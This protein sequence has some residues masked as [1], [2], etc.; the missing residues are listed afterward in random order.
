MRSDDASSPD[1][2]TKG[3]T[4]LPKF[5][6]LYPMLFFGAF[7][8]FCGAQK[9]GSPLSSD[10]GTIEGIKS[11]DE[12]DMVE[13][14][15]QRT[16]TRAEVAASTP[17]PRRSDRSRQDPPRPDDINSAAYRA[18]VEISR[19]ERRA[20]LRYI[21]DCRA[22]AG[23]LT[24]AV[25][26]D[27]IG[28]AIVDGVLGL[29]G[30]DGPQ[31]FKALW[32]QA[33]PH[34]N[35]A[36]I[37]ARFAKFR[38]TASMSIVDFITKMNA[39]FKQ[40][41]AAG[42][43][44]T[45][46]DKLDEM[47]TRIAAKHVDF[48]HQCRL[49]CGDNWLVVCQRLADTSELQRLRE[50]TFDAVDSA[51][52]L[53]TRKSESKAA[54]KCTTCK[55]TGH[56]AKE[57][58]S[59][60][61]LTQEERDVRF[62]AMKEK[63]IKA[64]T[65]RTIDK[66]VKAARRAEA[67]EEA[68]EDDVAAVNE[69]HA[70]KAD[71]VVT[72][73]DE[74]TDDDAV[75]E[76]RAS[77]ATASSCGKACVGHS[78]EDD[79]CTPTGTDNDSDVDD[80]SPV[81]SEDDEVSLDDADEVS[82]EGA[83]A[84]VAHVHDA[85][86]AVDD[87]TTRR[88]PRRRDNE[89]NAHYQ[90]KWST[91][92]RF[93]VYAGFLALVVWGF[94]NLPG[95]SAA[96]AN[97]ATHIG[98][99]A[100]VA[101]LNDLPAPMQLKPAPPELPKWATDGYE[102][103][104]ATVRAKRKKGLRAQALRA[105]RTARLIYDGGATH[106]FL[107][108]KQFFTSYQAFKD[109]SHT[110]KVADDS[111]LP[112]AGHGPAIVPMRD[113]LGRTVQ[114]PLKNAIHVPA[115]AESLVS[116][117]QFYECG[118]ASHFD[119]RVGAQL[120]IPSKGGPDIV[121]P[122]MH[123]GRTFFFSHVQQRKHTA[124]M[125]VVK[126]RKRTVPNVAKQKKRAEPKAALTADAGTG[127]ERASDQTNSTQ[128]ESEGTNEYSS[129]TDTS[130]H[131][132]PSP[133]LN[134]TTKPYT[135]SARRTTVA[136]PCDAFYS[137]HAFDVADVQNNADK[138]RGHVH[139]DGT[140]A[141]AKATP[142][143]VFIAAVAAAAAYPP[144]AG[145]VLNT[146][147]PPAAPP[148]APAIEPDALPATPDFEER[149]PTSLGNP[150][151]HSESA[152][153]SAETRNDTRVDAICKATAN[154][155]AQ[156]AEAPSKAQAEA[157]RIHACFGHAR[158]KDVYATI[159]KGM[160]LRKHGA[161]PRSLTC[162]CRGCALAKLTRAPRSK[163]KR[164]DATRP[165]E[166]IDTDYFEV[167]DKSF[168]GCTTAITFTD[169][170]SKYRWVF[171][172]KST[173]LGP[174]VFEKFIADRRAEGL[175]QGTVVLQG[176]NAMLTQAFRAACRRAG[177][178]PQACAPYAHWQNGIA[179]RGFRTLAESTKAMLL[180]A[181]LPK[182]FWALAFQHAAHVMNGVGRESV[183]HVT[184]HEKLHGT[185]FNA[186]HLLPFAELVVVRKE[187]RGKL[188]A[189]GRPGLYV[190][191]SRYHPSGTI[192]VFMPDTKRVVLTNAYSVVQYEDD[193]TPTMHRWRI[194]ANGADDKW[195]VIATSR[196]TGATP[197]TPQP[198]SLPLF[199][200]TDE[201]PNI[202]GQG[203][204]A[205]A[206]MLGDDTGEEETA[207]NWLQGNQTGN[208]A[209]V[210]R[211]HV[212][213]QK[214]L[215]EKYS[216]KVV[217]FGDG[218]QGV[219]VGAVVTSNEQLL[220]VRHAQGTDN[221]TVAEIDAALDAGQASVDDETTWV[222]V[223]RDGMSVRDIAIEVFECD[224]SVY[225]SFISGYTF[226][227]PGRAAMHPTIDTK[228][229]VGTE[230]P[231]PHGHPDFHAM[232]SVATDDD[233]PSVAQALA[234]PNAS[235]WKE[236]MKSH[237]DG[238]VDYGT[239]EFR[240]RSEL[241]RDEQQRIIKGKWVLHQKRDGDGNPTIKKARFVGKGFMQRN[242]IDF[243]ADHV[244]S[245]VCR[246]ASI[247]TLLAIAAL[248]GIEPEYR[249]ISHAYLNANM[250]VTLHI[251]M[252][253]GFEQ[254]GADGKPRVALCRKALFGFKQSG[255]LW[256]DLFDRK[257]AEFGF[258]RSKS[259]PCIFVKDNL[260]V[261]VYCDDL[262]IVCPDRKRIAEFDAQLARHFEVRN[263]GRGSGSALGM[264]I[265]V[266]G[267]GRGMQIK[268]NMPGYV[269][270][271]LKR[272][273]MDKCNSV[274]APAEAKLRLSKTDA[275]A[276]DGGM[277]NGVPYRTC[278]GAVLWMTLT[279]RPELAHTVNMLCRFVNAPT[280]KAVHAMRRLLRHLAR[281]PERGIVYS[282][283]G[284]QQL[285]AYS[286]SDW[287]DCADTARSTTGYVLMLAGAAIDWRS[288]LQTTVALSTVE[289][290]AMALCAATVEIEYTRGLLHELNMDNLVSTATPIG[291]DN[292]GCRYDAQNK[293]G[294]RTR[295]INMRFHRVREAVNNASIHVY[296]VIGGNDPATSQ[297]V[298]DILTKATP[299][300]LFNVLSRRMLGEE[301]CK[302]I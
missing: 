285:T 79:S 243:H 46:R 13:T 41:K 63:K 299:S 97:S 127:T 266:T 216:R 230:V 191:E 249:D 225:A 32:S 12:T 178:V 143:A 295:H 148:D 232:R 177:V 288:K 239:F 217:P 16:P 280:D 205:Q 260:W 163:T 10:D 246:L 211:E 113:K 286:D 95:A 209:E 155:D 67:R 24:Q 30:I 104:Q 117:P 252:P 25:A 19:D 55:R 296:K 5:N 45:D 116:M 195:P 61:S 136:A 159:K 218:D 64:G 156:Q 114:V 70:L 256:A 38:Q 149:A 111:R 273:G 262:I 247:R 121:I 237:F 53:F 240:D 146:S 147:L 254:T 54:P 244:A 176:D 269:N 81:G 231:S 142:N 197:W 200:D 270:Q 69:Y 84:R 132:F 213:M 279:C 73:T 292:E 34:K 283:D 51:V 170:Y 245:S 248:L 289:A 171:P 268:L 265:T 68:I 160:A 48:A 145:D 215:M 208:A 301:P 57:C 196:P 139:R 62:E 222:R 80:D 141:Y 122:V 83:E 185:K 267:K 207:N 238:L 264:K 72:E 221:F 85:D 144:V 108:D 119:P 198:G 180:A 44:Y 250:D 189:N 186:E 152:P 107:A 251:E 212:A 21:E 179:E 100:H 166:Y 194:L 93:A 228:F 15:A 31:A 17:A 161:L 91:V 206:Q 128:S 233:D 302:F 82:I 298:A 88:A 192:R 37:V 220:T 204:D 118:Y 241:T 201:L 50:I 77:K 52:A 187:L 65:W 154:K 4:S 138:A 167:Q 59:D 103:T 23:H 102:A 282:A 284:C 234:G 126:Q 8:R 219:I 202:S 115:F 124:H 92:S 7:I 184:P 229:D 33:G 1:E 28:A 203:E 210:G 255:R 259:D 151:D 223:P 98:N 112:M 78:S 27:T 11:L 214:A 253:E 110:V 39:F 199:F 87:E 99:Q 169:R 175:I 90:F 135:H 9:C 287:G 56:T 278:C 74:C 35:S 277:V 300:P 49:T 271:L 129:G 60:P 226:A 190:G 165:F 188:D 47:M 94:A 137:E 258:K 242:G 182:S 275:V 105:K 109:D 261:S 106:H 272:T 6:H 257:M 130:E 140:T 96:P 174:A 162:T 276:A 42:K 14:A 89:H 263:E 183:G 290:E 123:A 86:T 58:I 153:Q 236:A 29:T 3:G 20:A 40:L 293:T 297:M 43:T 150:A 66:R 164:A 227:F 224:P 172:I 134:S 291:V 22:I 168:S 158:W 75:S 274:R 173:S 157:Q 131:G 26:G 120:V 76:Y 71:K 193:G 235:A 101:C 133:V 2:R 36:F 281:D 294:K 181:R 18:A 125:P